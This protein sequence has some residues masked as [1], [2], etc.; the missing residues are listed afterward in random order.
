MR[1][2]WGQG[3]SWWHRESVRPGSPLPLTSARVSLVSMH[4]AV[5]TSPPCPDVFLLQASD[6]QE[7]LC[8]A[9]CTNLISRFPVPVLLSHCSRPPLFRAIAQPPTLSSLWP[10]SADSQSDPVT[11]SLCC[12][13]PLVTPKH[14]RIKSSMARMASVT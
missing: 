10:F 11:A 4:L 14:L 3:G 12:L 1:W 2:R 5:R 7:A 8:S 6:P 9:G 13:M